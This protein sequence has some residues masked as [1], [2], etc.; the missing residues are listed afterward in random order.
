MERVLPD[1]CKK[2]KDT[3]YPSITSA[4]SYAITSGCWTRCAN[5]AYVGVPFHTITDEWQLQ[6]FMIENEELSE[7]HTADNN[8]VAL[9]NVLYRTM[10]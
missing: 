5:D 8:A 7:Q 4:D 2:V 3:V 6:H 1:L 10:V 9:E